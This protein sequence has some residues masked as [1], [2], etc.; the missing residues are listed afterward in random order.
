M[1][2]DSH[3]AS[4]VISYLQPYESEGPAETEAAPPN[5]GVTNE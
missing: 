2:I 5:H 3:L 4:D 1:H